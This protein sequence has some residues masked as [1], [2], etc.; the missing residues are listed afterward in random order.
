MTTVAGNILVRQRGAKFRPGDA[1][2]GM[3]KDHTIFARAEGYVQLQ[4]R[5][6]NK[7]RWNVVLVPERVV[8]PQHA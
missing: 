4:R 8:Q 5:A 7:K 6:D 3:G 2:V 1:T